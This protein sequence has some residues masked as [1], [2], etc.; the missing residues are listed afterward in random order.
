MF[1][2]MAKN[3]TR[4][5]KMYSPVSITNENGKG[6]PFFP[7]SMILSSTALFNGENRSTFATY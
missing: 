2:T 3:F 4:G 1:L 5:N 6:K 7:Y